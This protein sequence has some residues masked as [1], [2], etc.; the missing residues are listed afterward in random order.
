MISLELLLLLA[1]AFSCLL[2]SIYFAV[3][4]EHNSQDALKASVTNWITYIVGFGACLLVVEIVQ[5]L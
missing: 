2:F 1:F 3:M 5:A 4:D